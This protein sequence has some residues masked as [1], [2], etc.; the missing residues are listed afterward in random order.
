MIKIT[1]IALPLD[2]DME[3]LKRLAASR[4]SLSPTE[5]EEMSLLRK[6]VDARKKQDVHFNV[7]VGVT[8]KIGEERV[9]A[10]CGSPKITRMHSYRYELPPCRQLHKRPVVVGA[11]PA[12]LFAALILAQAGQRPLLIERGADVD[13]RA[14]QVQRFW[15]G[16]ALN[17]ESNVQFGE[18]GA[19]TFSDGKLNTGTKDGRAAKVLQEFVAAGAPAEIL[20]EAKPHIGTDLLHGVVKKLREQILSLGG[21]VRFHTKLLEVHQER[22]HITGI[23]VEQDGSTE[24]IEADQV[25][26]ALGHSAR[27]TFEHLL[28][29]GVTIEQ[30]P[31]SIGARIEHLQE[32]INQ[33]QYGSFAGHPALG[34]ADYKLAVH[35]EN[36]RGVYTFCMCPGGLVVAA[37]SEEGRLVTNGMSRYARDEKNANAALL[38]G[39]SPQ[40]FESDHPLAG[41][42]FQRRWEEAAFRVGGGSYKAPAQ[43][44]GDFLKGKPSS[45]F[46]VE[47]SYLPGVI[48]GNLCDCLPGYVAE[49]MQQGIQKLENRLRGFGDANAVLTGIETRSSSPIR[50]IRGADCQSVS[51]GGLF[52]CGEGAGYAGGIVSAAVDGIRC[53]EAVLSAAL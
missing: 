46:A 37:A 45:S 44:V 29:Q 5:I 9:L 3:E 19:G 39:V 8:L 31:F 23:T 43:R 7:S 18:G 35:L 34:A 24:R 52:P 28:E 21:I 15:E 6:S 1:D 38:V 27:D 33:A 16:G 25:I 30:K 50:I 11:G 53:A 12:G 4:L 48:P 51:L 32:S 14:Q 2:A 13:T 20:Y 40:D 47:P 26:L 49:S 10:R 42:W 36:G 22:G 17:T 41:M